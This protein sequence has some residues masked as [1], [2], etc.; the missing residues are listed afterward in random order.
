[1]KKQNTALPYLI[2][3]LTFA[4][5]VCAEHLTDEQSNG[6]ELSISATNIY[7]QNVRG[8]ISKHRRAGRFSGS[9]DLELEADTQKLLG[10]ADGT[11]YMHAESSWSKSP[12]IDAPSIGSFFG[13]NADAAGRRAFDLTELWYQQNLGSGL[14]IRLGKLD[15]TGG[16]ECRGCPVSFDGSSFAND[17]TAQFLN[18]AL[19][20]NPTIPFPDKGLAVVLHYSPNDYWYISAAAADAQA[21]A[22]QTGFDTA[23]HKEDHFFYIIET[24]I[25]PQLGCEAKPLQ[26]AYRVGLWYDPQPKAN[27]DISKTSTDDIGF[28]TSFDQMLTKENDITED[29][30]GLGAF[31]RYGWAKAERN[32]LSNFFSFGFQYQGL[33]ENRDNDVLGIGFAHGSFSDLAKTTYTDDYEAVVGMY[34][35][36][37]IADWLNLTPSVQYIANPGG[38]QAVS[39]AV[40]WGLRAQISF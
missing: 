22:R 38:S 20:N 8:G 21:D 29:S 4:G 12:G 18:S 24:G 1:M 33:F 39:D 36:A 14:Q 23:F 26:G 9:F 3:I 6:L 25:A 31:F 34:Y 27:S 15:I 17:E 10:I 37:K 11:L 40:V 28:Y 32:D 30:Q 5:L 13:V 19:V 16:F 7:Q 2:L 35:N